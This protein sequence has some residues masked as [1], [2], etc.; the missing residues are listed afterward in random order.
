MLNR[1]VDNNYIMNFSEIENCLKDETTMRSY[2]ERTKSKYIT[3]FNNCDDIEI[4]KYD[5]R[6]KRSI[7]A[8]LHSA[9][10][11]NESKIALENGL[12][13]SYFFSLYYSVF[14][15]IYG[16]LFLDVNQTFDKLEVINHSKLYK[17]FKSEYCSGKNKV[18]NHNVEVVE[19][20]K[21]LREYYSYSMPLNDFFLSDE[22]ILNDIEGVE[23]LL[24]N[25]YQLT[26][27]LSTIIEQSA[28]KAGKISVKLNSN[29]KHE[30]RNYYMALNGKSNPYTQVVTL[31][32]ADENYLYEVNRY[33]I[34]LDRISILLDHYFDELR[35]YSSK[36]D[37]EDYYIMYLEAS[38]KAYGLVW[39]SIF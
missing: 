33:G 14:H 25:C 19:L 23:I 18:I 21:Y 32:P 37:D 39:N 27:L 17:Y 9:T 5:I 31:D 2:Y 12:L 7:K 3:Y 34:R 35:G 15:A 26:S 30:Y 10:F 36:I 22:K 4:I 20:L 8:M 24:I 38:T 29:T 6:M 13:G 11:Y 1:I 28:N 16:V